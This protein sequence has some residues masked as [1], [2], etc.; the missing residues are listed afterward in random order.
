MSVKKRNEAKY[1]LSLKR[2]DF[3]DETCEIVV[4]CPQLEHIFEQTF[5]FMNAMLNSSA[6]QKIDTDTGVVFC[7]TLTKEKFATMATIFRSQVIHD[8]E[9]AAFGHKLIMTGQIKCNCFADLIN[10]LET[11]VFDDEVMKRGNKSKL[12]SKDYFASN[13]SVQWSPDNYKDHLKVKSLNKS[14]IDQWNTL[15]EHEKLVHQMLTAETLDSLDLA[16]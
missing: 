10:Y 11:Y 8:N 5:S 9:W 4:E 3:Y 2:T 7:G 15:V 13:M 12:N 1:Q 16:K 14:R 6:I